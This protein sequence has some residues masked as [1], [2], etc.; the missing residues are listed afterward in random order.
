MSVWGVCVWYSDDMECVC[1][2]VSVCVDGVN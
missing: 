1:G 2:E